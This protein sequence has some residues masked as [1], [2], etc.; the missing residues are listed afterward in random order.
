MVKIEIN[1]KSYPAYQTMLAFVYF[2][3]ET[4]H[5]ASEIPATAV[6]E[7]AT[8]LWC[9]ARGACKREGVPFDM[10]FEEFSSWV[11]LPT[12]TKWG[13]EVSADTGNNGD[14]SKKN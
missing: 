7:T 5:E 9:C 1:G 10:D 2:K 4:G 14:A 3:R 8:F 13:N 12:L 6:S 11:D